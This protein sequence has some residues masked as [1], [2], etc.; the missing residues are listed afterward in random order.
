[1]TDSIIMER[2]ADAAADC[3]YAELAKTEDFQAFEALVATDMR[4][5]AA[6]VLRRCV[7]RFDADLVASAPRGWTVHERAAR[8]VMPHQCALATGRPLV[9][10]TASPWFTDSQLKAAASA[11]EMRAK[12][13][14][15]SSGRGWEPP[16]RPHALVKS[17]AISLSRRS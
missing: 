12:R 1:M 6:G 2:V 10:P 7:E 5:I 15:D 11:V 3:F 16:Y 9:A 8:T 13:M 14:P 17:V 4:A